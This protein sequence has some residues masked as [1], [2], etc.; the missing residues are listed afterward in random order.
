MSDKLH[1]QG[2]G[3]VR[4]IEA[5]QL[6]AGM[7]TVWNYGYKSEVISVEPS[8]TGKTITAMLKSMQDGITRQRRMSAHRLV[9][10]D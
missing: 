7:V 3:N 10:I 9:A 5:S 4:A 2:I 8:K 6:T 1:L